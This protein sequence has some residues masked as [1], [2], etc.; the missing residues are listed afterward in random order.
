MKTFMLPYKSASQGCKALAEITGM[1]R[2]K[3]KGSKFRPTADKVIVNWGNAKGGENLLEGNSTWINHP[4]AVSIARS[5]QCTYNELRRM[6]VRVVESGG[7]PWAW[8]KIMEDGETIVLR[9]LDKASG[10]KGIEILEPPK[11]AG[12]RRALRS[13]IEKY[14]SKTY[15]AYFKARDEYRVHV[16][17][18]K[19][20]DAQQKRKRSDVPRDKVNYK[21]RNHDNGFVFCRDGVECPELCL[22][23]SIKAVEALGLDF[24]AVDIRYNDTSKECAV[25]EVNTAP[26]LEGTTLEKYAAALTELIESITV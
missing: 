25:L 4:I 2:I 16:F 23:T 8:H 14:H 9:K 20:I 21:V 3:L 26:G 18:G 24:G 5:K 10:G 22:E 13:K 1:R 12:E 15:T 17:D 19:V 11:N 6:G 7:A